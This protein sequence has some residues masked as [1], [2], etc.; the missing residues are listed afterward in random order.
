[1]TMCQGAKDTWL[2]MCLY[3]EDTLTKAGIISISGSATTNKGLKSWAELCKSSK[4]IE[5]MD[6]VHISLHTT[7][8]LLLPNCQ[9][10]YELTT[11]PPEFCLV[12]PATDATNYK[13]QIMAASLLICCVDISSNRASPGK[14]LAS[15]Q[16]ANSPRS[17][18]Y[19]EDCAWT[20]DSM[21][22]C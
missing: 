7:D 15:C 22:A 10:D 14:I 20:F 8:K 17:R 13:F 3:K 12:R 4:E 2:T 1:M 19:I 16:V 21:A 18:P 5:L 6:Y 9:L 11:N